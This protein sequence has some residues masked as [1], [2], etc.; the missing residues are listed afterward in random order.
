MAYVISWIFV[1]A[2]QEPDGMLMEVGV[3]FARLPFYKTLAR[4]VYLQGW[5]SVL[6]LQEHPW[7]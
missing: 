1:L 4:I 7:I 3:R 6:K 5:F 2:I